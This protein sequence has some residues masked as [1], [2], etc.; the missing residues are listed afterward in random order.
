LCLIRAGISQADGHLEKNFRERNLRPMSIIRYQP[1]ETVA[2]S[3]LNRLSNLRD[4]LDTLFEMPFWSNF[5]GQS[6]LFSGWSPALDL[7]QN[8]DN[9]VVRVELPG[10]RKEDI[11]ISLQD[12]M[13]TISGERKSETAEGDKA[14]R[15]ERYVGKFRRS[16]SLPTQVDASKVTATYRDGILTVTLPK[17]EEAKPKQIQVNVA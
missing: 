4:E 5:G 10:M 2:W 9:V 1:P 16:I 13:L 14:E 7:Y 8:N 17:A 12:G 3:G 15:T 11:E 6:Q